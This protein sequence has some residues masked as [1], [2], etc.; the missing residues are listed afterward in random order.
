MSNN[1]ESSQPG[2]PTGGNETRDIGG[3]PTQPTGQPTGGQYT[4]PA[5]PQGGYAPPTPPQ[6]GYTPPP[7]GYAPPPQGGYAPPPPPRMGANP[8]PPGGYPLPPGGVANPAMDMKFSQGDFQRLFQQYK[9]IV[10]KTD[11]TVYGPEIAKA[12]RKDIFLGVGIVALITGIFGF[13]TSLAYYNLFSGFSGLSNLGGMGSFTLFGGSAIGSAFGALITGIIGTFITFFIGAYVT[14]WVAKQFFKGQGT[15]F[16][17]H[18]YLL[19]LSY[20]PLRSLGA[21]LTIIPVIGSLAA[22]ILRIY[23]YYHSGLAIQAY[24]K[25]DTL[26]GQLSVWIP[27]VAGI[28]V[29]VILATIYAAIFVATH[30]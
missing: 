28:V 8:P 23:Q 9:N 13:L 20:A 19:S 3:S 1:P 30:F 2:E 21:I 29:S 24:H 17:T 5:P 26:N 16:W 18:A 25:T 10:T 11:Y 15:D 7:G 22:L 6:G 12:N 4:P 14:F 27:V